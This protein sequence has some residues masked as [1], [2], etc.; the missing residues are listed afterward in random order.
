[1]KGSR[2]AEEPH[3]PCNSSETGAEKE[4][5]GYEGALCMPSGKEAE[6]QIP[7]AK[8]AQDTDPAGQRI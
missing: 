4:R 7:A 8:T 3:G 5:V 6:T 2:E 1:M